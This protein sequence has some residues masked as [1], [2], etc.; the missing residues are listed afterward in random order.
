[1]SINYKKFIRIYLSP[2]STVVEKNERTYYIDYSSF[3]PDFQP[4]KKVW[5]VVEHFNIGF[6]DTVAPILFTKG[7][8]IYSNLSQ[9][10]LILN[11][12]DNSPDH[13]LICIPVENSTYNYNMELIEHGFPVVLSSSIKITLKFAIDLD[14]IPNDHIGDYK[15]IL[16]FYLM[17]D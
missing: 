6:L 14:N 16:R 3:S 9:P 11:G 10:N 8:Y 12:S 7:M 17:D 5:C 13:M 1:M 4:G 15:L 2:P